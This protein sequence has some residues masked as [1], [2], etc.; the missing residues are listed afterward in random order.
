MMN[1]WKDIDE[2]DRMGYLQDYIVSYAKEHGIT[3]EEDIY[4][5]D[6]AQEDLLELL[7]NVF[8]AAG[9]FDNEN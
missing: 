7:E 1:N 3:V 4:Q 9:V 8:A 5:S 6:R 2:D